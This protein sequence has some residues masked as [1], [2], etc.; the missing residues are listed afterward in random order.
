M[1][2]RSFFKFLPIAPVALVA[3]GAR[4]VTTDEIP[5]DDG[6]RMTL[7]GS[8]KVDG[9]CMNLSAGIPST[10]TVMDDTKSVTMSVGNDGRL[11][12][13]SKDNHW[14]RVVTE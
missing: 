5:L 13:K 1:N 2:R 10:F 12:I 11:W 4:A 3:E 7:H 9:T 6:V 14:R 8:K